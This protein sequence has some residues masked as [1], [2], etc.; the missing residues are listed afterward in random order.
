MKGSIVTVSN[1]SHCNRDTLLESLAALE[2]SK[3]PDFALVVVNNV[4]DGSAAVA[5]SASRP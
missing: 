4:S 3:S 2:R 5:R 1:V